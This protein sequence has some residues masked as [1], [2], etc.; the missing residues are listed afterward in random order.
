MSI[1]DIIE[2][3]KEEDGQKVGKDHL[4]KEWLKYEGIHGY[5]ETIKSAIRLIYGI[6]VE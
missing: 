1:V 2:E 4:F 6:E 3:I 5:D